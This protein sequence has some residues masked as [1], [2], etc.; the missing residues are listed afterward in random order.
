MVSRVLSRLRVAARQSVRSLLVGLLL[1][2]GAT[3]YLVWGRAALQPSCPEIVV[4][5]I[6]GYPRA[7]LEPAKDCLS[8]MPGFAAM[9]MEQFVATSPKVRE[10]PIPVDKVGTSSGTLANGS[11]YTIEVYIF[12]DNFPETIYTFFVNSDGK[13]IAIE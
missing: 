11:R 3:A 8:G 13:I 1:L 4:R 9:S 12:H 6:A 5:V 10:H 2:G 7:T